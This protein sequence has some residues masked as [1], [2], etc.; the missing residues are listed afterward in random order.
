MTERCAK[1]RPKKKKRVMLPKTGPIYFV[2]TNPKKEGTECQKRFGTYMH[3]TTVE[4]AMEKGMTSK[5]L[6]WD[7][8]RNFCWFSAK[9]YRDDAKEHAVMK[10]GYELNDAL[11]MLTQE[12]GDCQ[13]LHQSH[14]SG[15]C[16]MKY[17]KICSLP[18]LELH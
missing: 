13:L 16:L 11:A 15:Q 3:A 5:D 7:S 9:I 6:K 8:E 12:E 4:E 10:C 1:Q 17:C 2:K 18:L 14:V